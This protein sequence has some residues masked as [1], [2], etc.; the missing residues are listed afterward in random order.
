[1]R[2]MQREMSLKLVCLLPNEHSA[3]GYWRL[4]GLFFSDNGYRFSK[5][6]GCCFSFSEKLVFLL[7]MD[8]RVF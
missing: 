3:G 2:G 7:D 1:M 5:G 4:K 6:Y 8:K